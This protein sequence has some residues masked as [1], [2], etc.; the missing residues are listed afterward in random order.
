MKVKAVRMT[1]FKKKCR[2]CLRYTSKKLWRCGDEWL[3]STCAPSRVVAE[4][5]F[6]QVNR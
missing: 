2:S 3:C 1:M 4:A 5:Y 6:E